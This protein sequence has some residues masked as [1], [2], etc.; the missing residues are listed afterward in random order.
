MIEADHGKKFLLSGIKQLAIFS[1][2]GC[3]IQSDPIVNWFD[4][5]KVSQVDRF[6]K[7]V[8]SFHSERH[9]PCFLVWNWQ[10]WKNS[11]D[12]W[13]SLYHCRSE[14]SVQYIA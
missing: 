2:T 9:P 13:Q 7:F 4:K 12:R 10:E 11:I 6:E 1:S 3:N 5:D 14:G 8:N